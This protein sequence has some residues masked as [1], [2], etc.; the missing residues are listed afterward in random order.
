M[1]PVVVAILT[2]LLSSAASGAE[3]SWLSGLDP[4]DPAALC[5]AQ[6]RFSSRFP[7]GSAH[8][9]EG[10]FDL[11]HYYDRSVSVNQDAIAAVGA[12]LSGEQFTDLA[13]ALN[14]KTA[15][16]LTAMQ[17]RFPFLRQRMTPWTRCGYVIMA[18]FDET[19]VLN[20]DPWFLRKHEDQLMPEL[21]A[22]VNLFLKESPHWLEYD[23]GLA[24][25]WDR[26]RSRI[27][28][29]ERFRRENRN[30]LPLVAHIDQQIK[31]MFEEYLCGA[32]NSLVLGNDGRL[33]QDLRDSYEQFLRLNT[34]SGHY[35]LV[36][37]ALTIWRKHDWKPDGELVRLY[38]RYGYD[39]ALLK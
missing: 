1:K 4:S 37:D 34:D 26:L 39:T 13:F 6:E 7:A 11:W 28:R 25:P 35:K 3:R 14:A 9:A 17:A 18:D 10:L 5:V 19:I 22:Y 38:Q 31:M 29:W 2:V 21:R 12:G 36:A 30:I 8:Q 23:G 16:S 27:G 33:R 24:I 20:P 15:V 32:P